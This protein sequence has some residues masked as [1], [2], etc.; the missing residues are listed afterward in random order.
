MRARSIMHA[1]RF[2]NLDADTIQ[3]LFPNEMDADDYFTPLN[4]ENQ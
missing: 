3:D 4:E 2:E 1:R